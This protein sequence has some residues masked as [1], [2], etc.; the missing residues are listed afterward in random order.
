MELTTPTRPSIEAETAAGDPFN[1]CVFYAERYTSIKTVRE[2]LNAF[3]RYSRHHFHFLPASDVWPAT[4]A[5]VATAFDLSIFDAV[6]VH[7]SVRHCIP[8]AFNEIL[9]RKLVDYTGLKIA[10]IQ[11]EYDLTENTR[12]L[13]ERI[14]YRVVYTCVPQEGREFVYPAARF[15]HTAFLPTLTGY[16]PEDIEIASAI[17]PMAERE[18]VIAYRGRVLH[19]VYGMLAREKSTIGIEMKRLAA[20][21]GLRV[22]IEVDEAHR[23]YGADWYRFLGSARATLGTESGAN[24]FDV[25]GSLRAAV[26]A[27]LAARPDI[28]FEELHRTL[29]AP[30]EGRVRMNQVSPKIFEAIRMRTALILFDGEYS[31]AVLPERHY[32]PLRKDFSN[33]DDVF[34]RL[35]DLDYLEAL[36]DRAYEEVILT[37]RYSY[38]TFVH[39]FDRDLEQR[40][41]AS[42]RAMLFSTPIAV[43]SS[44][45]AT[46][47]IVP[48]HPVGFTLSSA[49]LGDDLQREQVVAGLRLP[50][51][52]LAQSAL[53][54][55]AA[56]VARSW[57]HRAARAVWR[58]LPQGLRV[59][60]RQRARRLA[61]RATL[62]VAERS[63]TERALQAAWRHALPSSLRRKLL[64]LIRQA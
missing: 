57:P 23:V 8:G 49:I 24:V 50:L 61:E 33:A 64:S 26:D 18:I 29:L 54:P 62:P 5:Q 21:R 56:I 16:V 14:G 25:D 36:T 41:P 10:F 34:D 12:R 13:F 38:R 9:I 43:R 19:P 28:P 15:P 1:I 3:R 46:R 31:G 2:H 20:Q 48:S 52:I 37:G 44:D 7:Y 11:D 55:P 39:S 32:I 42:P 6:V 63:A 53:P 47:F 35:Q 45:G 60:A 4:D 22:D 27:A 51:E 58:L 40:L 17:R 30:H 59:R